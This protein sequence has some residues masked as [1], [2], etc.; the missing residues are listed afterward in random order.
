MRYSNVIFD[1]DGVL[2]DNSA[3]IMHSVRYALGVLGVP[4]PGESV[5][6]KFIGPALV[7]SLR[8]Y[9]GLSETDAERGLKIYREKYVAEGINMYRLYDGVYDT[10]KALA[11][12]GVKLSVASGKPQVF[13]DKI[14]E[15]SGMTRFFERT[16]GVDFTEKESS[17]A[18]Q[19]RRALVS[20]PA[21]M[22]GDRV[23]DIDCARGERV[24]C[25]FAKYGFGDESDYAEHKPEY[26]ID[27][28]GDLLGIVFG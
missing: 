1:M 15:T 2:I 22:V 3:G 8:T 4:V 23:F 19:I 18:A 11:D 6:R 21:L 24:D 13:L 9:C 12:G 27:K 28:P 10:V 7:W 5:L 17:K 26:F 14:L 20:R 25:A 16:A